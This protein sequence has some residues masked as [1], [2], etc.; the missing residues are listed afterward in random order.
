MGNKD[1]ERVEAEGGAECDRLD[2]LLED[3]V[4]EQHD[5]RDDDRR[6]RTPAGESE[7]NGVDAGH[8][9]APM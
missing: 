6:F 3:P 5:H 2:N 8:P 4:R 7:R 9:H 1:H